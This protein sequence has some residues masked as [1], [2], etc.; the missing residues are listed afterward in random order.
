MDYLMQSLLASPGMLGGMLLGQWPV[1]RRAPTG[2]LVVAFLT[3]VIAVGIADA[4]T[5]NLMNFYWVQALVH[6]P[7][8]IWLGRRPKKT[9]LPRIIGAVGPASRAFEPSRNGRTLRNVNADV[10]K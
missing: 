4:F 1:F 8:F 10:V 6:G 3:L 2:V 7:L 5:F 9:P